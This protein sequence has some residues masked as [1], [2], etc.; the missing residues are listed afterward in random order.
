[1]LLI[2]VPDASSVWS[3]GA[4]ELGRDFGA[5]IGQNWRCAAH[6]HQQEPVDAV[7]CGLDDWLDLAGVRRILVAARRQSGCGLA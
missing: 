6:A 1:M 3:A 5:F 4:L 2:P 7:V